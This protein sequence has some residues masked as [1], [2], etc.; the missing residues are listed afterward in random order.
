MAVI[1]SYCSPTETPPSHCLSLTERPNGMC[2][3][4]IIK[5]LL[6]PDWDPSAWA[7]F[8]FIHR[9]LSQALICTD[10]FNTACNAFT[11]FRSILCD[12]PSPG[13][14][15][16][17]PPLNAAAHAHICRYSNQ[18]HPPSFIMCIMGWLFCDASVANHHHPPPNSFSMCLATV[19]LQLSQLLESW[20]KVR[21]SWATAAEETLL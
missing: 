15:G 7:A 14:T 21:R 9:N 13:W 4:L 6:S 20:N 8:D 11:L 16:S 17:E 19:G 5:D 18:I 12:W 3:S 1:K 2:L 10:V